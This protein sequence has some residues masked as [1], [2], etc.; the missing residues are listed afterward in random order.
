MFL[1]EGDVV[2]VL[3]PEQVLETRVVMLVHEHKV[4]LFNERTHELKWAL[5]SA[6][7]KTN[8][9]VDRSLFQHVVYCDGTKV[10]GCDTT[11]YGDHNPVFDLVAIVG[12]NRIVI[13]D[14]N[15]PCSS[16][17]MV[18]LEDSTRMRLCW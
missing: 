9:C 8:A 3:G 16:S 6:V 13:R 5:R 10:A 17:R 2:L 7:Q 12:L 18:R 14:K 15:Q 1:E 11:A 4:L